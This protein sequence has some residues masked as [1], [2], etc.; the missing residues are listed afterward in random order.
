MASQIRL[1]VI[2]SP[3]DGGYY[4]TIWDLESGKDLFTSEVYQLR[5]DAIRAAR[6]EAF[7]RGWGDGDS[8]R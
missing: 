1:D 6:R 4:A 2:F 8:I 5:G 7:E 3:D